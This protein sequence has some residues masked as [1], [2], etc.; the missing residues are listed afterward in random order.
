MKSILK[1]SQAGICSFFM[2]TKKRCK[3]MFAST[4]ITND[5]LYFFK[6]VSPGERNMERHKEE[7]NCSDNFYPVEL[8]E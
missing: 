2:R 6:S 4:Y 8:V 7:Y 3:L 1:I 5:L